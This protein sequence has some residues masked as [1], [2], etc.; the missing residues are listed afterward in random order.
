MSVKVA[1]ASGPHE[2]DATVVAESGEEIIIWSSDHLPEY[3]DPYDTVFS[4]VFGK[5][6][7]AQF[8]RLIRRINVVLLVCWVA[9]AIAVFAGFTTLYYIPWSSTFSTIAPLLGSLFPLSHFLF[10]SAKLTYTLVFKTFESA[11]LLIILF[12]WLLGIHLTRADSRLYI[13]WPLFASYGHV[14]V[15]DAA[16][17]VDRDH[18]FAQVGI[19]VG[20]A[21]MMSSLYMLFWSMES[22]DLF[23]NVYFSVPFVG[24]VSLLQRLVLSPCTLLCLFFAKNVVKKL[25]NRCAMVILSTGLKEFRFKSIDEYELFFQ[26]KKKAAASAIAGFGS[27]KVRSRRKLHFLT[28]ISKPIILDPRRTI[29]LH[30]LGEHLSTRL[31]NTF[32]NWYVGAAMLHLLGIALTLLLFTGTIKKGYALLTI[33]T[34]VPSWCNCLLISPEKFRIVQRFFLPRYLCLCAVLLSFGVAFTLDDIR[35][36]CV[37]QLIPSFITAVFFDAH[38]HAYRRLSVFLLITCIILGALLLVTFYAKLAHDLTVKTFNF[39]GDGLSVT[40]TQMFLVAPL[41]ASLPHLCMFCY[42]AIKRPNQLVSAR[43]PLVEILCENSETADEYFDK[44]R[45][46]HVRAIKKKTSTKQQH[47]PIVDQTSKSTSAAP[48]K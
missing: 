12:L 5:N 14:T 16:P 40:T 31:Q 15:M 34:S 21:G 39:T 18:L 37:V 47:P 45:A 1:P 26:Q 29:G 22:R 38:I 23:E 9:G 3:I 2:L 27:Q 28:T 25:S 20:I 4:R 8:W 44:R 30:I 24:Q 48:P 10:G 46:S 32:Q 42:L 33:A 11:Y 13:L 36:V 17:L 19:M 6:A 43:V 41:S 7:A 35:S